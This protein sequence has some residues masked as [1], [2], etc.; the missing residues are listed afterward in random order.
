MLNFDYFFKKKKQDL[1]PDLLTACVSANPL[2]MLQN[3]RI[4]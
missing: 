1:G 2:L 4:Y 3:D